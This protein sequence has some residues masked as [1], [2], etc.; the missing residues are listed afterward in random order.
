MISVKKSTPTWVLA[1]LQYFLSLPANLFEVYL[2]EE[3]RQCFGET[4]QKILTHLKNI[5]QQDKDSIGHR[6][7]FKNQRL[8]D[9]IENMRIDEYYILRKTSVSERICRSIDSVDSDRDS[10]L[11]S[12]GSIGTV[13]ETKRS[14]DLSNIFASKPAP[15]KWRRLESKLL[16]RGSF[17]SVYLVMNLRD[18][19]LMAM[20]QMHFLLENNSG[21]KAIAEEIEILSRMDHPNLI[22]YYG[23]EIHAE[24]LMI[25]MEYCSE[26]TLARVC[27][28]GLDLHCVR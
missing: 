6:M 9:G 4:V 8:S 26:G 17:G 22:R 18:N 7:H 15:F 14:Y 16:G 21:L 19:C 12:N 27:K 20:K 28:E 1:P 23:V 2:N 25:F 3:D 11:R 10:A 24:E 13:I 5:A